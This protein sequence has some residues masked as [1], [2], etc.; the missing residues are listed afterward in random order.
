MFSHEVSAATQTKTSRWSGSL[1]FA[2]VASTDKVPPA[3]TGLGPNVTSEMSSAARARGIDPTSG[4]GS[5]RT[6]S[7][8]TTATT[9][10]PRH[11][12]SKSG[13]R[14]RSLSHGISPT[15]AGIGSTTSQEQVGMLPTVWRP[16]H[17]I[18]TRSRHPIVLIGGTG[19]HEAP[20]CPVPPTELSA[21]DRRTTSVI[22]S[23]RCDAMQCGVEVWVKR[24]VPSPS[25]GG[26]LPSGMRS[27]GYNNDWGRSG[28]AGRGGTRSPV[29]PRH[30]G[31]IGMSAVRRPTGC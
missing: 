2:T 14:I 12:R 5:T 8:S 9:T 4:S 11:A 19:A 3:M 18:R 26:S 30:A 20:G 23:V 28:S 22:P 29:P 10:P 24:A 1:T 16:A 31:S 27:T 17:A 21:R 13:D 7:S 25:P 6:T 15:A